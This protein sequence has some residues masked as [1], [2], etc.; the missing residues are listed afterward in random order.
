M[1]DFLLE[2]Y[3]EEMPASFLEDSANNIK[4]LLKNAFLKE[5]IYTQKEYCFFTPKRITLIFY[6]V[7]LESKNTKDLIKGP[8]YGSPDKAIIGFARSYDT[9]KEKLIVRET[10]RGKYYFFKNNI[11]PNI[12]NLLTSILEAELKRVT[13]KK[14]MKW[15]NHNLR[16]ARPLKNIL[17]LFNNKKVAFRLEHLNST[18]STVKEG[19]LVEKKYKV[20][21]V[22]HY[23]D[24][25]KEF[26]V[27][28]NQRE[29]E[30]RIISEG[31]ILVEKK[32]L[33]MH[34]DEKLLREV[35]NLV[36]KP[37]L[38]LAK[39]REDYLSLPEEILITTMKKNQK[40]F[41]LYNSKNRLSNH[42]LLVSNIKPSDKGQNIIEGNQRVVN[43]RL[44]DAAFFWNRDTKHN[45]DDYFKKLNKVIFHNEL[46]TMQ[47]KVFRLKKL[48]EFLLNILRISKKDKTDLMHAIDL[49]K[50]D[51]VTEVVKEFPELQGVMGSYYAKKANY[52]SNVSHAIYDQYKPLGPSDKLPYTK[53]G[54]LVSLIDKIDNLVGFFIIGRQPTSSKDPLALRRTA[55]GIIR[56]IVEG[57]ID[58]NLSD[59]ILKSINSYKDTGFS[60]KL[61]NLKNY[62]NI[63]NTLL[64]FII[65]RYEN[66]VKDNKVYND[67]YFRSIKV[68]L[69]KINFLKI[70]DNLNF[71]NN[72]LN[73]K[74]GLKLL[75]A[76]KR[77]VNII[78]SEKLNYKKNKISNPNIMLFNK[79]EEHELYDLVNKH[80]DGE[81][82]DSET[83]MKNLMYLIKPIENF[84]DN[85]QINHQ[86]TQLKKNRLELLFYVN[87]KIN[88]NI[89]FINLIKRN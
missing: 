53:L 79:R 85:V 46:G 65:E 32:E 2:F 18:D 31:R 10:D 4:K 75:K 28:I 69:L 86:N 63:K 20:K 24:L 3:S 58:L 23:L 9:V 76:I 41:P 82:L 55:L 42:F 12:L 73:S 33:A 14:S 64:H 17:C 13:W 34:K 83:L 40:Y 44:E 59:I 54:K 1:S 70:N 5:N 84:F 57:K 74:K 66:L 8:S 43:A 37:Y 22:Q 62:D 15:A 30:K 11:K 72:F 60:A 16:W 71:L 48:A 36:E 61:S 80:A 52:N 68:D 19:L 6:D 39:F 50:N 88:Q 81:I 77:V 26:N 47:D 27:M 38:F 35:C 78:D 67:N 56:I 7:R 29:R 51:L 87:N 21:S 89:N 25:M 45:F 49:L